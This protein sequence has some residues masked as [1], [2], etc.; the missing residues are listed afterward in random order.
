MHIGK[1]LIC[2]GH[3]APSPKSYFLCENLL[4]AFFETVRPSTSPS[5]MSGVSEIKAA[6]DA[7]H[8]AF[9]PV[10]TSGKLRKI[11]VHV[12]KARLDPAKNS[13]L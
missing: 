4:S 12:G 5:M 7:L 1:S 8:T 2:A 6:F 10:H 11:A 3:L 9:E 13:V